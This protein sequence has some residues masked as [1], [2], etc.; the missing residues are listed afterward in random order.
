MPPSSHPAH[1]P[2]S[3]AIVRA[4]AK[5]NLN[6]RI[7]G[8]RDD[9]YHLLESAVVFT[10]FGDVLT[11]WPTADPDDDGDRL[12]VAGPFGSSLASCGTDNL[13]LRAVR[14]FRGA[15]GGCAPVRIHLDKQIP[16]GAGLGGGSS[17]AAAILRY[18]NG[19]IATPLTE[20]RLAE[21]ALSLGADVPVCLAGGAQHMTG[22]GETV[23]PIDPAPT[24][25]VVL[26]RPDVSLSTREVFARLKPASTPEHSPPTGD[27]CAA[28]LVAGGNDLTAAAIEMAPSIATVLDALSA[29]AGNLAAQMS[30]SGSAC[31]GLF[32][33][34]ACAEAAASRLTATGFWAV[35]TRF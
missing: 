7:T 30:G 31:F 24:G 20:G 11:I 19:R 22:I 17:N 6:L 28:A 34:A 16:T 15:A 29:C 8:R 13:C 1:D 27:P 4:P 10:A 12:T 25:H 32:R 5:L 9:G 33:D 23:V 14:A 18:L 2:G 26:A 21:L 3:G 35:A